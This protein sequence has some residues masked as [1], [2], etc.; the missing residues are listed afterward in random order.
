[1][2]SNKAMDEDR[3]VYFHEIEKMGKGEESK[4]ARPA[5]NRG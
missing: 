4:P 3:R 5:G 2:L 1:M